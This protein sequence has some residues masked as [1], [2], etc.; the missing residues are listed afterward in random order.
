MP[1]VIGTDEA[2][3]GPNLG[4]LVVTAT[5]WETESSRSSVADFA[6]RLSQSDLQLR[7]PLVLGDSKSVFQSGDSIEGLEQ[8][9]LSAFDC[10][11][12]SETK[13]EQVNSIQEFIARL[14]KQEFSN[15]DNSLFLR[16]DR[17]LPMVAP[18]QNIKQICSKWLNA[19][20]QAKCRL[21]HVQ[22][23]VVFPAKFNEQIELWNNKSTLLT[24]STLELV[25][26]LVGQFAGDATITCDRHGG[27]KSYH[28]SI[29]QFLTED[30]IT[31]ESESPQRSTYRWK[32]LDQ[33]YSIE[34][35]TKGERFPEVGL[36]SMVSKYVRELTMRNWNIYWEEKIPGI[37]P[38]A[39]YPVDAKRFFEEIKPM[40]SKVGISIDQIW[41][42]R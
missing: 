30:W 1:L 14:T 3:L 26:E 33:E 34:F 32:N 4:P 10:C 12:D 38:T 8:V 18:R 6:A 29:Q 19:Q 5:V 28:S 15:V 16:N 27:R 13:I 24:S 39:G 11:N 9:V 42:C 35:V 36:A 31:I 37:K 25:S 20:E 7:Y 21:R 17:C 22:S 2:G 23:R 41:R 40:T